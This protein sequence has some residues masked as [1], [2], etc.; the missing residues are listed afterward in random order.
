MVSLH[1]I[2]TLHGCIFLKCDDGYEVLNGVS[3]ERGTPM[4]IYIRI[5][6]FHLVT[7]L[8]VSV[9]FDGAAVIWLLLCFPRRHEFNG[10]GFF[11]LEMCPLMVAK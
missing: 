10:N 8:L 3:Q 2:L 4:L 11:T 6:L 7:A 1:F 5:A 9:S